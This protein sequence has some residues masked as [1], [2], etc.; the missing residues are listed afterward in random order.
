MLSDVTYIIKYDMPSSEQA[1][2]AI[3]ICS[4]DFPRV[5]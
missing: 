4:S 5:D 1:V 2:L 3:V